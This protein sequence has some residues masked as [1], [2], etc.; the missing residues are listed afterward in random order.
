VKVNS[1]FINL[2]IILLAEVTIEILGWSREIS[3][4]LPRMVAKFTEGPAL[5]CV[6]VRDKLGGK[7]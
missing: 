1:S 5:N 7:P 3:S 2:E 4:L 6:Q